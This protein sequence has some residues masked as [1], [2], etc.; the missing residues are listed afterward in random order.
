MEFRLSKDRLFVI[1]KWHIAL[2]WT[3]VG[4]DKWL[5]YFGFTIPTKDNRKFGHDLT[6]YDGPH[7][8]FGLWY[9]NVAWG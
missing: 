8:S 4:D 9:V 7:H 2:L 1:E 3:R 6:W 5:S